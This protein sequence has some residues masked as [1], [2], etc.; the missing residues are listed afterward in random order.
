MKKLLATDLDGTL[1]VRNTISD[2]NQKA[3]KELREKNNIFAVSTGRPLN[4]VAYLEDE[5][6]IKIDY[7]ILLN[8]A[9]ILDGNKN[10]IK[11]DCIKKEVVRN[12][13]DEIETDDMSISIESGY[14]TYMLSE[15]DEL[16]YPNKKNINGIDEIEEEMS[17]ISVYMPTYSIE[18]IDQINDFINEKYG[19]TVIG[20]RNS[21]YIDIVPK[22]CSKGNGVKIVAE[23]ESIKVD[24]IYTIGDS[25]NDV[26]MFEVSNNSFTFNN[27]EESL[28]TKTKYIVRSVAECIIRC[29]G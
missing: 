15:S 12:I 16:P 25:W 19:Q 22:G 10:I 24:N 1:V 29:I 2:E 14:C 7:Y 5:Y 27:V 23:K 28:K 13:I 11:Y 3:I 26:T 17:L 20:Y 8:G 21:N 4:G 9:F 6:N 18:K